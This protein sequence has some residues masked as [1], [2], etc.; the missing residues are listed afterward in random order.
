MLDYEDMNWRPIRAT[1]N[2]TEIT[3]ANKPS[4][5]C[6]SEPNRIPIKTILAKNIIPH[7]C[8]RERPWKGRLLKSQRTKPTA[9]PR[10]LSTRARMYTCKPVKPGRFRKSVPQ[11]AVAV[12][13]L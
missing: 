10:R 5:H 6:P 11:V 1:N 4:I 2:N 8:W 13:V 7:S 9:I 12:E 3:K